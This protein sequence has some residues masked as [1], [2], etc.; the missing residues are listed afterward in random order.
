MD[1]FPVRLAAR[2]GG[3]V[4]TQGGQQCLRKIQAWLSLSMIRSA[5]HSAHSNAA[6]CHVGVFLNK[7]ARVK[8]R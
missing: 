7:T 5:T 8:Q 6:G 3:R 1:D 2:C 4:K